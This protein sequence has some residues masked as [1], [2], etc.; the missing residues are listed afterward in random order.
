M[1]S[2]WSWAAVIA[3]LGLIAGWLTKLKPV[4]EVLVGFYGFV[5]T[6]IFGNQQVL[7]A[8]AEIRERLDDH[9]TKLEA[10]QRESQVNGG[11]SM[12]DG[13]NEIRD[14]VLIVRAR[15]DELTNVGNLAIY[16]CDADGR[17]TWVSDAL[18]EMF[19]LYKEDM[20]GLG[21]LRGI[22]Q[23]DKARVHE[24]WLRSVK[25]GYPFD[26]DYRLVDGRRVHATA[27][28]IRD[29]TK[30]VRAFHGAVRPFKEEPNGT[31]HQ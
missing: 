29:S 12:R 30:A 11:A 21:W 13:L 28:A 24:E 3:V 22:H 31:A 10:L 2:E 14:T 23:D 1:N 4:K 9:G 20:I 16:S 25:E 17:C 18:A 5:R 8:V 6:F 15:V 19:G 7:E 27:T 26:Y